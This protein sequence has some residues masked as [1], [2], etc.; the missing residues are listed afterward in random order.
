MTQAVLSSSATTRKSRKKLW[1]IMAAI[2]VVGLGVILYYNV[3]K[4]VT[5]EDAEYI[6]L[7]TAGI[8]AKPAADMSYDEQI[9]AL[10]ATQRAV[11]QQAR[12]GEGIP[13]GVP[14]EPKNLYEARQGLCYDR[15]R[16][17]EKIFMSMGFNTRHIALY[18]DMPDMNKLQELTKA[19]IP[20]HA[21][22]EVETKKGWMVVD[23]NNLW[24]ALDKNKD[25]YSLEKME[26]T[27]AANQPIT[28]LQTTPSGYEKFYNQP[29]TYFYGL[30]S[31]HGG[32]YPPYT[33]GIP[34]YNLQELLYN[35]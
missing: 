12:V 1:A 27:Y 28:W 11:L 24:L 13:H 22:L 34:D 3:S 25:P 14:R 21:T 18:A 2:I 33:P 5:Q 19:Q 7:Y 31:R 20:S 8:P 15:S 30:Y 6:K 4:D 29:C 9:Q 35:I 16:V 23:S 17:L 10:E 26:A 32:F